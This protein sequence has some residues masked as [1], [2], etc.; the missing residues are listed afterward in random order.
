VNYIDEGAGDPLILLHGV[1]DWSFVWNDIIQELKEDY[2]IV[3]P[4]LIG[5]GFSD[6]RDCFDRSVKAQ[7]FA[8]QKLMMQIGIREAVIVGHDIGGAVAQIMALNSPDYVTKMILINSVCYDNWPIESML[9]LGNPRLKENLS[10]NQLISNLCEELSKWVCDKDK[11]KML[12]NDWLAPLGDEEGKLSMIRNACSLNTNHTMEISES[13]SKINAP[14]LL[15]WGEEDH[16]DFAYAE[17]LNRDIPNSRLEKIWKAHHYS[18][19][20]NPL[21]IASHIKSFLNS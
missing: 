6:R 17:R 21:D 4:D 10:P 14:T 1:P 13:L 12:Q 5:Y 11:F 16:F 7:A 18:I 15:L 20:D 19:I 2:R 8:V 9:M 3:A